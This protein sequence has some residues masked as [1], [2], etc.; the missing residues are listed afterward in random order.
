MLNIWLTVF[1][2]VTVDHAFWDLHVLVHNCIN[3][4]N[5]IC[6]SRFLKFL[7]ALE[8]SLNIY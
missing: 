2:A 1:L 5:L 7:I 3:E 4:N 6:H 8:M